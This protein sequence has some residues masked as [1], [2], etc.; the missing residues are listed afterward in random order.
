[1]KCARDQKLQSE[2]RLLSS[3]TSDWCAHLTALGEPARRLPTVDLTDLR[4]LFEDPSRF[5]TRML[6][7]EYRIVII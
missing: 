6:R 2:T 5:L 7:K 1:V 3:F 4:V